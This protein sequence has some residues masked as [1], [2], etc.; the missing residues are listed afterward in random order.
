[1]LSP[2]CSWRSLWRLAYERQGVPTAPVRYFRA[3]TDE[4]A[5]EFVSKALS[6]LFHVL[7]DLWE[8]KS[9]NPNTILPVDRL[10]A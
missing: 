6:P 1:M 2:D 5:V 9:T 3:Q 8:S 7:L 10:A 4:L